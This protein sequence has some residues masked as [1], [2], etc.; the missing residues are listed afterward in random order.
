MLLLHRVVAPF[1]ER[2]ATKQASNSH[3]QSLAD[4]MTIDC[5]H[6]VVGT[7]RG[8]TASRRKKGRDN[9]LVGPDEKKKEVFSLC[10]A[11]I[12]QMSLHYESAFFKPGLL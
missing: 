8:K 4:A 12:F 3:I 9:Q 6:G 1:M 10:A 5:L 7:G 11:Q 2:M